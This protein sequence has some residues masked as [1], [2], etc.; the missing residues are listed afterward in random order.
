VNDTTP[1]SITAPPNVI[2]NAGPVCTSSVS[3]GT[4][5]ATDNC[6]S[7]SVAGLR[8][9]GQPLS[10]P[11]PIGTT[12]IT[13]TGTDTHGNQASATQTITVVDSVPPTITVPPNVTA[14]SWPSCSKVVSTGT[15]TASDTCGTVTVTSTRS[16]GQPLAAAF[17][18][19]V[20]TITW[21]AT[22]SHGNVTTAPQTVTLKTLPFLFV[23]ASASPSKLWPATHVMVPVTL[24]YLAGGGCGATT[25]AITSITSSEPVTGPGD[26]TT[27]DWEIVDA[28]HV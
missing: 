25:C 7:A 12:T 3:A 1:P 14:F 21:K 11:Y 15:A 20:T 17:N 16:D 19:G 6:G 13:W 26:A 2:T 18:V 4:A 8:S 10:A 9:D 5:S 22:D 27:P 28:K 24:S 23:S